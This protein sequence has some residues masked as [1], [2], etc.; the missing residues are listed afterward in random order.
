M[1]NFL[2]NIEETLADAALLEMG[3]PVVTTA[4]KHDTFRETLE[5]NFIEVAFAEAADFDQIH[6]AILR[7]HRSEND[8][9]PPDFCLLSEKDHCFA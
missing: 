8:A 2:K 5:E 3:V 9:V 6:E 7:E 1:K 4:G